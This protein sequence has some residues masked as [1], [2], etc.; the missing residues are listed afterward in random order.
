MPEKVLKDFINKECTITLVGE[1][2]PEI[3][4]KVLGVEGYWIKIKEKN[5]KRIING[6]LVRDIKIN[7]KA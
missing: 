7:K 5:F 1:E 4:G 3:I 6:A 2:H